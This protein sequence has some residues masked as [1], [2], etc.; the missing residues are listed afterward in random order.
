MKKI[1]IPYEGYDEILDMEQDK[2]GIL[3]FSSNFGIRTFDGTNWNLIKIKS[4][5]GPRK[6]F[7]D[8]HKRVYHGGW[9]HIGYIE[10]SQYGGYSVHNIPPESFKSK[11]ESIWDIEMC[12][13]TVYFRSVN[14]LQSYNSLSKETNQWY[15]KSKVG[16]ME[17][18]NNT[19]VVQDRGQGLVTLNDK[20][21]WEPSHIKLLD[22]KLIYDLKRNNDE[23]FIFS[24]PP[25]QQIIKNNKIEALDFPD[26]SNLSLKYTTVLPLSPNKY[27]FGSTYGDLIFVDLQTK[28]VE[29]FNISNA[30]LSKILKTRNNNLLVLAEFDLFM[31]SWPNPIRIQNE[32]NGLPRNVKKI[33][34]WN[35]SQYIL[36]SNGIFAQDQSDP[37]LIESFKKKNWSLGETWSLLP[38]SKQQALFLDSLHVNLIDLKA[39]S[40][41]EVSGS[42]YPRNIVQSNYKE[43]TY[44][45]HT[46]YDL[47][48][49][50]KYEGK[51]N[52]SIV[53]PHRVTSCV[54]I[55]E[56]TL[57]IGSDENGLIQV[58]HKTDTNI[59]REKNISQ[60]S[61][62]AYTD[63]NQLTLLKTK[64]NELYAIGK[65]NNYRF[66]NNSFIIDDI[67][68]LTKKSNSNSLQTL[69][70]S[71]RGNLFGWN[72]KY[73]FYQDSNNIWQKINTHKFGRGNIADAEYIDDEI[74][75]L[76]GST[77]ISFTNQINTAN[78]FPTYHLQ[79]S[80]VSLKQ[81][82]AVLKQKIEAESILKIEQ[83]FDE[84]K[85]TYILTELGGTPH[86]RYRLRGESQ[87]WSEYSL[88]GEISFHN[89]EPQDYSFEFQAQDSHGST[90][91][92][93]PYVFTVTPY[94]Y[95]SDFMKFVWLLLFVSFI[96]LL[97]FFILK[98]RE[99]KYALQ[100][101]QLK[102]IINK[103]TSELKSLNKHLHKMAL[104]D[105]L[106]GLSNRNYLEDYINKIAEQQ[107]H[108]LTVIMFDMDHFKKYNDKNGHLAGD[109]LLKSL[110]NI[111]LQEI[112]TNQ[113]I[114]ARYGGEEFITLIQDM[115]LN[116]TVEIAENI[117]KRVEDKQAK[118]SISIGISSSS[119]PPTH[120][121]EVYELIDLADK[122][123]YRSKNLGRNMVSIHE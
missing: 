29:K 84:I 112:E 30:W 118:V 117:R 70:Q 113:A 71:N 24:A 85:F 65:S 38:I 55:D 83:G 67:Q 14:Y 39:K 52:T 27:V 66:I 90:Y 109:E 100:E 68:G 115:S 20:N 3:Y 63:Y 114:I 48:K 87:Q 59:Y 33:T 37:K 121:E 64:Q 21:Q 78:K 44:Y 11:F 82:A 74:S 108:S 56:N 42:I 6:I 69:K 86:Y 5:R 26:L 1:E 2:D 58:S 103:K 91:T 97:I 99:K 7:Y 98:W 8:G 25:M 95:L 111:L 72:S 50:Q 36:S 93:K 79:L 120:S 92:G 122:A 43:N 15:F 47:Q 45:I 94:W 34:R 16:A 46:E 10:K 32:S 9:N 116:E 88:I 35:N 106:T 77:I 28:E 18:I 23:V 13:D 76:K 12:N 89:L 53:Y 41:S 96:A 60:S 75:I 22:N 105:G 19:I 101:K 81:K 51:W 123:L 40:V 104:K 102:T 73:F 31:I 17:C 61:G 57:L 49:L 80:E 4:P 62:L 110:A 107:I 119:S 54:E